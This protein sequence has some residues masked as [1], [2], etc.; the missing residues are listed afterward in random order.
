MRDRDEDVEYGQQVE[1]CIDSA[2]ILVCNTANVTLGAFRE[3][4]LSYVDLIQGTAPRHATQDEILMN[5]AHSVAAS[6][7]CLKRKVGALVADNEGNVIGLGYNENPLP[8]SPCAAEPA[9]Q[10]HCYR[11]IVRDSHFE[12]LA[13]KGARCPECGEKLEFVPGPPWFCPSCKRKTPPVKTNLEHFFFP[14]RA[15]SW[16]TAIHA[17]ARALLAAG[18]RAR[19]GV[20]FTTT[21]PCFQCAEK[22]T[23]AGISRLLYTEA[24]PDIKAVARLRLARIET[25]QFEGVRSACFDRIFPRKPTQ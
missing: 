17:E 25:T 18:E 7:K 13:T 22:I 11:D 12:Q 19:K 14:D 21:F 24:Y 16:C 15:M 10:G 8:T 2:D 1:L 5:M 3:K 6:S 23:Q 4:M 9:Y 20:L